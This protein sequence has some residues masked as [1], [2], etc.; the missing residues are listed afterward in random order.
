MDGDD[1]L[2]ATNDSR[3]CDPGVQCIQRG[4]GYGDTCSNAYATRRHY[5]YRI[6]NAPAVLYANGEQH[7]EPG[8]DS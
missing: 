2:R 7:A 3:C 8:G 1:G 6:G 4:D 5:A